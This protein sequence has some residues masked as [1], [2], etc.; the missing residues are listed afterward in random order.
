MRAH[1]RFVVLNLV[2]VLLIAGTRASGDESSD[3]SLPAGSDSR[4]DHDA[5]VQED[6]PDQGRHLSQ[7]VRSFVQWGTQ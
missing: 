1:T 7:P 4:P 2:S 6:Q 5:T 3:S